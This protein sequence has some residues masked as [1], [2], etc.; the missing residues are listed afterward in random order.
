MKCD[1]DGSGDL[2]LEDGNTTLARK[3]A[4]Y[5]ESLDVA[6]NEIVENLRERPEVHL[7]VVFGSYADG[8]RDLLTDLDLLIVMESEENFLQRSAT[9]RRDL[10]LQ[11]D[12]D[13]LVYTPREFVDLE[14]S[15]FVRRALETGRVLYAKES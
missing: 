6:V 5:V 4:D 13:L 11:V 9:L 2:V 8:R 7:V 1:S 14:D 15:G 3:R 10:R 12:C